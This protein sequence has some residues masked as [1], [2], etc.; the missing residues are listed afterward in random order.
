MKNNKIIGVS[1]NVPVEIE[2]I[3]SGVIAE[4]PVILLEFIVQI[5]LNSSF[6]LSHGVSRIKKIDNQIRITNCSFIDNTD[7]VFLK[8]FVRKKIRY[9]SYPKSNVIGAVNKLKHFTLDV[10]FE[11]STTMNLNGASIVP[12]VKSNTSEVR[13]LNHN[14]NY[15]K[16]SNNRVNDSNTVSSITTEFF[17]EYPYCEIVSSRIVENNEFIYINEM[18]NM[19]MPLGV[20]KIIRIENKMVIYIRMKLLQKQQIAI[21]AIAST[22]K[23]EIIDNKK[24]GTE[25]Q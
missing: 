7:V 25:F 20:K 11:C 15:L 1:H 23:K 13:Y 2:A 19:L 10:P 17:N 14:E 6:E 12:S 16:K 5:N 18:P 8:G 3:T 24:K 22:Y 21:P 9:Y 4:V